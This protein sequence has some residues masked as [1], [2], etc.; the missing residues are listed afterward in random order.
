MMNPERI[1]SSRVRIKE[2]IMFTELKT[3]FSRVEATGENGSV[4]YD[5]CNCYN[6]YG[7]NSHTCHNPFTFLIKLCVIL[8]CLS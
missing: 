1:T 8:G 4:T 3:R 5:C 6:C 2:L 7:N